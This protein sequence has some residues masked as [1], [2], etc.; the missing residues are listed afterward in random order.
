MTASD[1]I[2]SA[3]AAVGVAD[4]VAAATLSEADGTPGVSDK[5]PRA[6]VEAVLG[7]TA[8][9]WLSG[10]RRKLAGSWSG[11]RRKLSSSAAGA[12]ACGTGVKTGKLKPALGSETLRASWASLFA[13]EP[14]PCWSQANIQ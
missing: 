5:A 9:G 4:G 12:V 3:V 13:T 1:G 10:V 6:A 2:S 14:T 8:T 11:A 7:V